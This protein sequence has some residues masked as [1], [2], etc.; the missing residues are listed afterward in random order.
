MFGSSGSA[1]ETEASRQQVRQPVSG[2]VAH[3]GLR[4]TMF[5][6]GTT[7]PSLISQAITDG[8]D[9][10]KLAVGASNI[11]GTG[12]RVLNQSANSDTFSGGFSYS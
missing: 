8:A 3:A 6:S 12:P 1:H 11:A 7:S 4:T 2:W 5:F 10:G 9:G